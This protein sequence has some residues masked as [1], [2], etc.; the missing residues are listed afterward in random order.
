MSCFTA[1]KIVFKTD[2]EKVAVFFNRLDNLRLI[3]PDQVENW[4]SDE[5][6][7]SFFI[8]NLGTLGMKKGIFE[9]PDRF[10]LKSDESSKVDFV[11]SFYLKPIITTDNEGY[12]EICA[13]M[14]P[15]IE[16]MAKRPLTNFVNILTVNLREFL[17]TI[18]S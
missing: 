11:L 18:K 1:N 6:K 15:V 14:N 17:T 16:M 5:N 3:M 8:K 9:K 7:C 10:I 12:F 13:E 2:L 4:E